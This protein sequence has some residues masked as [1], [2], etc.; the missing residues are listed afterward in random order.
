[1]APK[2]TKNEPR[3]VPLPD[4]NGGLGVRLLEINNP[5]TLLAFLSALDLVA[6]VT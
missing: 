2:P 5:P 3:Y 6:S 1:M 4:E